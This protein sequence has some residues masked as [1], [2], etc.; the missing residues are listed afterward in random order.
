[1]KEIVDTIKLELKVAVPECLLAFWERTNGAGLH[2]DNFEIYGIDEIIDRNE[3]LESAHY[4]PGFIAFSNDAGS[5]VALLDA[6]GGS[7]EVLLNYSSD[8]TLDAMERTGMSMKDWID[9][10]CPFEIDDLPGKR[11]SAVMDVA[12]VLLANDDLKCLMNLRKYLNISTSIAELRGQPI[13]KEIARM[14]YIE[15]VDI[16]KELGRPDII[17]IIDPK[18][19]GRLSEDVEF[20]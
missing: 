19:G 1:M 12:I 14:S 3:V 2:G 4:C 16:A 10:N 15:A 6:A 7:D 5:R 11:V 20:S 9:R 18:T 13:G 17:S 8:M